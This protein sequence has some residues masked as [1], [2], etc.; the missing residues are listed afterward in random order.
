[1]NI[2]N[3]L[4]NLQQRLI[5]ALIGGVGILYAIYANQYTFFTMFMFIGINCQIEFYRLVSKELAEP[6]IFLGLFIGIF[7]MLITFCYMENWIESRWYI[8]NLPLVSTIF[9]QELY[10]KREKPFA[11]ISFTLIG[12]IYT[13][14]PFSLLIACAFAPQ[15]YSFQIVMGCLLMLWASDSGAYF[16]GKNLGKRK[17]FERIS[18]KKTWEGSLGGLLSSLLFA[19][20]LS[21]YFTDLP[22]WKWLVLAVIIVVTGSYGDLVESLFKRSINIK[23][24]GSF[25]PGHGGFLDRFDGLLLALPF[26]ATFLFIF[27]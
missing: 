17:L 4:S 26:I 20:C 1:M 22:L 16:A 3:N 25:I 9:L 12:I 24:S 10:R 15:K 6:N 18:P 13:S 7:N 2:L 21:F 11:N 8:L 19:Y 14:I 23:D 27:P 5:A